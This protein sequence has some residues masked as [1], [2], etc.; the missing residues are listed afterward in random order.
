MSA[1]VA[2]E[3][4]ALLMPNSLSHY[5]KDEP[6][7]MVVPEPTGSGIFARIGA[8]LR[9]LAQMPARRSVIDE[10]SSLSDHELADIG[11]ARAE[12][13]RVFDTNFA[14]ERARIAGHRPAGM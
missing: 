11:L 9:W 1:H 4:M 8:A 12:L 3:E 13:S 14:A 10:L 5:F 7:Y 2:K 6:E